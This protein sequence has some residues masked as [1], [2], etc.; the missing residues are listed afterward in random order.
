ME[1]HISLQTILEFHIILILNNTFRIN[2]GNPTQNMVVS[3]LAE[4]S[5]ASN[6]QQTA[7]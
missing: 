2:Y 6:N 7:S 3:T 5:K 4:L 1:F